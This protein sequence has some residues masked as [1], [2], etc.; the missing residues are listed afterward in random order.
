MPYKQK[1]LCLSPRTHVHIPVIPVLGKWRQED[2]Y[3]LL[4]SQP[5]LLGE[6]QNNERS[7]F[8]FLFFFY[9]FLK[10]DSNQGTIEQDIGG[11][12]SR[13]PVMSVLPAL[14]K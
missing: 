9:F 13:P 14:P 10:V 8:S 3:K 12:P 6:F 5:R 2:P 1:D 7:W 11:F 4:I